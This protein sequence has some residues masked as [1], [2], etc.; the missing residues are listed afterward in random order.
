MAAGAC[1]NPGGSAESWHT[2]YDTAEKC[3]KDKLFWVPL[4]E[5]MIKSSSGDSSSTVTV[6][7][8]SGDWYVAP[9]GKDC[10]QDCNEDSGSQCTPTRGDWEEKYKSSVACCKKNFDWLT[11]DRDVCKTARTYTNR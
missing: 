7:V 3:C 10:V 8:G 9:D 6:Y 2:L 1:T 5:C 4:E 11:D